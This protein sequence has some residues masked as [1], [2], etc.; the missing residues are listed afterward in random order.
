MPRKVD[1]SKFPV[2]YETS[3]RW[4]DMDAY[5]HL[6]NTAYFKLFEDVRIKYM[7]RVGL[8]TIKD[9]SSQFG[10]V[11][12]TTQCKYRLPLK[13]PDKITV[14]AR[15]L[16]LDE[17]KLSMEYAVILTE[18]GSLAAEGD[19]LLIG[20]DLKAGQSVNIPDDVIRKMKEIQ[21]ELPSE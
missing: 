5:S 3:V 12:A 6:N 20:Y 13:Y 16:S 15:I 11:V 1:L 7:E 9:V 19:A 21:P 2:L 14:A 8:S 10:L 4:G 18:E 17:K